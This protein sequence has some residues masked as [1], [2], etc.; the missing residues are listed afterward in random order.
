MNEVI[1]KRARHAAI[2]TNLYQ[3]CRVYGPDGS[4]MFRCNRRRLDW[5]LVR[6]LAVAQGEDAIQLLFEP[7]G[8]GSAGDRYYLEDRDNICVVCGAGERLTR[9]HV[10]PDSY[11]RHFP[12]GMTAHNWFD[13][14]L[15]C[16]QCHEEYE[17]RALE[18]RQRIAGEH[19][20]APSG[21]APTV[22]HEAVRV[23]KFACALKR[24]WTTIPEPRREVLLDELR[25]YLKKD[26]I[27]EQDILAAS[28]LDSRLGGGLPAGKIVIEQTSDL[29]AF[30][31][32]WREHFITT[33]Q[34]RYLS[35]H[36]I[37]N[38]TADGRSFG[39]DAVDPFAQS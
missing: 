22:D 37:V 24:H 15:L 18:L 34:P 1:M 19:G 5:Y 8:P 29:D 28:E 21:L 39:T 4:L 26:D 32:R 10:V 27:T 2:R 23:V 11:R 35:R 33:M 13:V 30:V 12:A 14:L 31:R 17:Q 38:R 25:R 9:H 20:I 7:K 36:W 3:N 16:I 6:G